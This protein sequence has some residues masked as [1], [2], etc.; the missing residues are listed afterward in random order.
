MC[1]LSLSLCLTVP[2]AA[3][4]S[5][6]QVLSQHIREADGTSGQDTNAGAGVKTG[7]IQD[8]AVT[9][10]KIAD[11]AVTDGKIAGPI[12]G[13]KVSSAGLDADTLD[14][15]HA[16][17][18]QRKYANTLVVAKSG[19]DFADVVAALNSITDS[20]AANP[21]LVKIMPGSYVASSPAVIPQYVEVEGSGQDATEI[22]SAIPLDY[23][24]W[25][26]TPPTQA[27][28]V[29]AGEGAAL[30]NLR[31]TNTNTAAPGTMGLLVKAKARVQD[32]TVVTDCPNT[33]LVYGVTVWGATTSAD[34]SGVSV[35]AFGGAGTPSAPGGTVI[36]IV[37]VNA[38]HVTISSSTIKASQG[39]CF[40]LAGVDA[41]GTPTEIQGTLIELND[42][43]LP[44][45]AVYGDGISVR[46]SVMKL[47]QCLSV[48]G[49]VGFDTAGSVVHSEIIGFTTPLGSFVSAAAWSRLDNF[50]PTPG[51][52]V[53]HC[54][55]GNFVPI[56]NQ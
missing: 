49:C 12:S 40:W 38:G 54:V 31:V 50:V 45:G 4:V 51:P 46:G 3:N 7:H 24:P 15:G 11:G 29:M 1:S 13:A 10:S 48:E 35:T 44:A 47:N 43:L 53:S 28:V 6:D 5:N 18:F 25:L 37:A 42:Q 22:T 55:D 26:P 27:T 30:R 2:A 21:Y 39:G 56:P 14:G 20:S 33:Q 41:E 36:A 52:K 23:T 34:L 32:V 19:G 9:N 17:D 8:S 16:V